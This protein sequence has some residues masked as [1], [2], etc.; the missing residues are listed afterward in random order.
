MAAATRGT[1]LAI[2]AALPFHAAFVWRS[3]FE[4]D[5]QRTFTL[6]DDAMISMRY[7]RNLADGHGLVWDPGGDAVEG[8]SNLLWTLWMAVVHAFGLSDAKAALVV[9]VTAAAL[10]AANVWVV[11]GLA[12][13]IAP[14]RPAVAVAAAWA[15]AFLYPLIAWSLRGMEVGLM[16]L[17][18]TSAALLALR[19]GRHWRA[20]RLSWLALVLVVG[21]L[22]RDDFVVPAA[23]VAAWAIRAADPRQRR[24]TAGWLVGAVAGAL[25]AHTAFRLAVY[26]EPLANTYYLKLSGTSLGERLDRGVTAATFTLVSS[27]Y[28][29]A[30]LAATH[31]ALTWRRRW[32]PAHLLA[33]LVVALFGYSLY[34]GGDAWENVYLPNRYVTPGVPLLFVLAAAGVAT[35]L[36][37]APR[38]RRRAALA[39]AVPALVVPVAIAGWSP[40]ELGLGGGEW[41][42]EH[43]WLLA[44]V[45]FAVAT[46][47]IAVEARLRTALG[48]AA[49]VLA[50]AVAQA[51]PASQWYDAGATG[52]QF[53]EALARKGLA[54]ESTTDPSVSIAAAAVGNIAYFSR[55][56]TVDLLGKMDPVIAREPRRA[57]RFRPGHDKWDYSRSIVQLRP[58]V[59]AQLWYP[60]G[61]ELCLV[62]RAGYRPLGGDFYVRSGP[63]RV[64]VAALRS[65]VSEIDR[66]PA[67]AWPASCR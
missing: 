26:G 24:A 5:G 55:R 20:S 16:T 57:A 54:I 44:A 41:P 17:V 49:L 66:R 8:Y 67:Q 37:A 64:Q 42:Y 25:A 10:L 27:L 15:T 7:A 18:I 51:I 59:L 30:L 32:E 4:V 36:E 38:T 33:A 3:S 65:R 13:E 45:A 14:L 31:L 56:P 6:V 34:V 22:V 28:P 53:D 21:I 9:A 29:A 43:R 40:T 46:A 48:V 11:R 61:E 47:A 19:L 2:A 35:L 52:S 50:L 12:L 62:R 63:P 39:I 60:T 58:D 23:V 1:W